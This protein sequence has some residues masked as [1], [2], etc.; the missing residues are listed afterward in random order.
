MV[1]KGRLNRCIDYSCAYK[2]V[3]KIL[4]WVR[5]CITGLQKSIDGVL[6][7]KQA[8]RLQKAGRNP[9]QA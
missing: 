1:E 5:K 4:G 2:K 7:R 8:N 6:V 9:Q 3:V